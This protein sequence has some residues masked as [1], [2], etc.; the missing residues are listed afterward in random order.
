VTE[1][2]AAGEEATE[3]GR[4]LRRARN[5]DAAIDALIAM[6]DE[7]YANPTVADVALRAGVS[8]RSLFRY[9]DDVS[10]LSTEAINRV[11][12]R[13][14]PLV[15]GF[16]VDPNLPLAQRVELVAVTADRVYHEVRYAAVVARV[17]APT[18]PAVAQQLAEARRGVRALL[19]RT[20]A[21]ELNEMSGEERLLAMAALEV[22][23]TFEV[24][25]LLRN[26]GPVEG[27][28]PVRATARG[29]TTALSPTT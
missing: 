25:H 13:V 12:V 17:K 29:M 2:V 22:W 16:D 14:L 24:Q 5:R 3:D 18:I 10:D 21:P 26:Q 8:A 19:E 28:D 9:F 11:S 4:H 23:C 7:G 27:V 1:D 15:A 20:F 6:M